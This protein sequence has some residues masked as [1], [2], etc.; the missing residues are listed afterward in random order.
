[1]TLDR[2]EKGSALD[3]GQRAWLIGQLEDELTDQIEDIRV[4]RSP[5]TSAFG[6][7]S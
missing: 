7:W 1:M 2:I 4:T 5:P 3:N 6:R